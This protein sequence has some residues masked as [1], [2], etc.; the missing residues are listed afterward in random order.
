MWSITAKS[1]LCSGGGCIEILFCAEEELSAGDSGSGEA[2][3][4]SP[5]IILFQSW[6]S[7]FNSS[8]GISTVCSSSSSIMICR[9]AHRS[10]RSY[11]ARDA[12]SSESMLGH[13]H[14]SQRI[15]AAAT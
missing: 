8:D 5:G 9:W 13:A 4:G 11:W 6:L 2:E 1:F 15:T 3:S 14:S 10:E 7:L 12:T